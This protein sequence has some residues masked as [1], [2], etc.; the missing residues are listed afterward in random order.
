MSGYA[1]NPSSSSE[2]GYASLTA[3]LLARKGEA[4]PAVDADA[5]AGVDIDMHLAA[6]VGKVTKEASQQTVGNLYPPNPAGGG[7]NGKRRQVL[8][9]APGAGKVSANSPDKAPGIWSMAALTQRRPKRRETPL[10]PADGRDSQRKATV[11]FRMPAHDFVRLRFASRDM[12]M[13]CQS[14]I[15]EAL[16]CYLDANDVAP[17]SP[18]VCESEVGRL[19]RAGN[20]S[21]Q[22]DK[23]P[24][25][26]K[27]AS[28][29]E[30]D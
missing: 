29:A 28:L 30:Q 9:H 5:H 1:P 4:M 25:D 2:P 7:A 24:A 10:Q 20:K 22:S 13:S 26:R 11:R 16:D 17:V 6:P 27:A 19:M 12:E 21:H 14:I 15:L 3:G 8:A 23:P 18:E